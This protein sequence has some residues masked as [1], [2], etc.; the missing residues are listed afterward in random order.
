[1][2]LDNDSATGPL[3]PFHTDT[4]GTLFTS[5]NV[6]QITDWNYSYSAFPTTSGPKEDLIKMINHKYGNGMQHVVGRAVKDE[7]PGAKNDYIINVLYNRLVRFRTLNDYANKT[8]VDTP[9]IKHIRSTSS[10]VRLMRISPT[11]ILWHIR[12]TLALFAPLA[13]VDAVAALIA[14][15]RKR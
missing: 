8:S 11:V 15:T 5:N 3:E 13:T 9:L 7:I 1:L 4:N 12:T 14:A 2:W 10:L 6:K